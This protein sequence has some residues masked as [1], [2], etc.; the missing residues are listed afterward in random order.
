MA[1]SSATKKISLSALRIHPEMV[2]EVKKNTKARQ[3]KKP[4]KATPKAT[5]SKNVE[6][7]KPVRQRS[8]VKRVQLLSAK[9]ARSVID[10]IRIAFSVSAIG[11]V[12][13]ILI[14]ASIPLAT[15]HTAH[16]E[17]K[18][19][20]SIFSA[21]ICG[22]LLVSAKSVFLWSKDAFRDSWK[23]FGFVV[24]IEGTMIFSNTTWL[25]YMCLGILMFINA[26]AAG[27]G[28]VIKPAAE[29]KK[30]SWEI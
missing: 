15:Y 20:W 6:P 3:R 10:Q 21:L 29:P 4:A 25:V 28:L 22:G 13:G 26:I 14:G 11:A 12:I 5:V 23:A 9:D 1:K 18:E 7:T 27:A 2:K 24:L 16:Y 30:H 19:F 8:S 17:W